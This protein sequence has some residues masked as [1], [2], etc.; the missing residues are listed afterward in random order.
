VQAAGTHCG[1]CEWCV[2]TTARWGSCDL[3][4]KLCSTGFRR[5]GR[6]GRIRMPL[7]YLRRCGRGPT[8]S[9]PG[10]FISLK[11]PELCTPSHLPSSTHP[12]R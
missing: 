1:R 6:S 7:P 11:R 2:G 8:M 3:V 10:S 12:R 4:R 9:R 5:A